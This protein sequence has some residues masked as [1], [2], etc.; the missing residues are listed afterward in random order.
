MQKFFTLCA[1]LSLTLLT[2]C[3][4]LP[5]GSRRPEL[6]IE[7]TTLAVVDNVP[8]FKVTCSLQHDSLEGLPVLQEDVVVF[9]NGS[10]VGALSVKPQDKVLPP[11]YALTLEYFVPAQLPPAA[12]YGIAYTSMLKLPASVLVHLTFDTDEQN[13]SFNPNATYEG[14]ISRE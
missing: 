14:I 1:A 2:A 4:S 8:G 3:Q 11:N 6:K 13:L 10:K 9:V 5:E 7:H 12:N